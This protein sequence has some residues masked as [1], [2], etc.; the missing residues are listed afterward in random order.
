MGKA[1]EKQKRAPKTTDKR[2]YERFVETAR[3]LG[4]DESEEAFEQAFKKIVS[5]RP[6]LSRKGALTKRS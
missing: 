4:C 5:P 3:Q 6:L 1:G 2:E